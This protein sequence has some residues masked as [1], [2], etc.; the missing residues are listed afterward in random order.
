MI[1]LGQ[2]SN[3]FIKWWGTLEVPNA[4]LVVLVCKVLKHVMQCCRPRLMNK[5]GTK[6]GLHVQSKKS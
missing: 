2:I 3:D 4:L 5:N 6:K 1:G